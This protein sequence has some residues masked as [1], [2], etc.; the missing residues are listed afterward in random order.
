MTVLELLQELTRLVDAGELSINS[1]V[2][3]WVRVDCRNYLYDL[4]GTCKMASAS[5]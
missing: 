2:L 3:A 5:N 4:E 1:P